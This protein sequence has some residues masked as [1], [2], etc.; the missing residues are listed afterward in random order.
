MAKAVEHENRKMLILGRIAQ[1]L[2]LGVL[3]TVALTEIVSVVG[4]VRIFRYQGF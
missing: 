1:G 3:V 4:D 2:I